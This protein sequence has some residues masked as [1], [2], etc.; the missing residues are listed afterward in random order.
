MNRKSVILFSMLLTLLYF[1]LTSWGLSKHKEMNY[2][3]ITYTERD[4]L[5]WNKA[6]RVVGELNNAPKKLTIEFF[7]VSQGKII[8]IYKAPG[9]LNIYMSRFLPPG[10]YNVTFKS[11]GYDDYLIRSVKVKAGSDCFLN[12]KFG[13][14]VFVN[15]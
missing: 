6:G 10:T 5:S 9:M 12:M 11:H 4:G 3:K 13:R 15:R 2:E 14:K 7:S 1:P 8:Y